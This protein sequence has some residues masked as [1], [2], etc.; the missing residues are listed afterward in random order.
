[1]PDRP[2]SPFLAAVALGSNLPSEFGDRVGNVREAIGRIRGLGSVA[3]VSSLQET[4]PVGFTAQPRFLNGA[5]LLHTRLEPLELMRALLRIERE[6]G[7]NR[8]GVPA[9]GPRIIDLDLLFVDQNV[10]KTEELTLPHPALA[11]RGFVLEPLLELAPDWVHP[12]LHLSVREMVR[13]LEPQA[14]VVVQ[15]PQTMD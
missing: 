10:L 1:M 15:R 2:V 13:R 7:R 3:A 9:K 5:L 11:E 6:M 4:E 14:D 8:V 12:V